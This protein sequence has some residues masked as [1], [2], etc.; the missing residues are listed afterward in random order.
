MLDIERLPIMYTAYRA[1]Y[2]DRDQRMELIDAVVAGEFE[3]F[4]PDEERIEARTP[5]LV[6]VALEDTA[7]AASLVPTIRVQPSKGT[8]GAKDKAGTTEQACASYF[9]TNGI[10]LLIQRS[11]MDMGAYGFST[12]TI[13]PDFEQRIPLIERRDPRHCYPEP[14]FRLGDVAHRVMFARDVYFTALPKKYQDK[15]VE[16]TETNASQ[17][18]FSVP[19]ENTKVVLIEF[20][21]ADEVVVAGLYSVGT[22]FVA[23]DVEFYPVELDR[24]KHKLGVCPVVIGPRITLD[25][26]F[27]GQFDQVLSML[28]A[29]IRLMGLVL[30]YADQ[31][32]YSDIWVRD[33]IGEMSYG[34]GSY[35]ELGPQGAIGRVPPAVNSLNIQQDIERLIEG[36]HLGG[37]WPKARPGQVDQSIASAKFIEAS[38]GMMNT[39][40]RTYH[41]ILQK[42]L[43]KAMRVALKVDVTHFPGKKQMTGILRNQEFLVEYN[44]STDL[45]LTAKV[46]VEY[47]LGLGKDPSQ[48]AVLH[49]QYSQNEFISKLFAQEN[50]EGI[51]DV[52]RE[53]ERMDVDKFRSMALAKLMQGLEQ[54]TIPEKALIEMA[55][56]RESGE[57]LF[58]IY[59]EFIIKPRE[60]AMA[61]APQPGLGGPPVGPDGQPI[62]G[63]PP[64]PE[65]AVPQA[66][67]GTDLLARI[68]VPAGPGGLLGSQSQTQA[69]G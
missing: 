4:D 3:V 63:A 23:G 67:A 34:G 36:I 40:I 1:R 54:G 2:I 49:I 10:D 8:Q 51:R 31:A 28:D 47:G 46:R 30:D 45:D 15:I 48:S 5:N 12:W 53:N 32:V 16:F 6:Q 62:P 61:Q 11:V 19:E 17:P 20:F 38:A 18:G 55:K 14:G 58:E 37:R 33:L 25:G 52:N 7:E 21:D 50:T 39:A 69:G 13:L 26:E 42:M 9:D 57:N 24:V 44:P 22:G 43:E 60:E 35:I 29:H 64:G 66:P 27:R 59:E 41:L 68:G 56:K 65:G